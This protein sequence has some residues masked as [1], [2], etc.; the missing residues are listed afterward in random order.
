MTVARLKYVKRGLLWFE[1]AEKRRLS[2]TV[3]PRK[4]ADARHYAPAVLRRDG[5]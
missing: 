3:R 5:I 4:H 2:R 1:R